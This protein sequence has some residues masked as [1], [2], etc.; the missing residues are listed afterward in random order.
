MQGKDKSLRAFINMFNKETIQVSTTNDMKKYLLE[1]DLCPCNDFIKD[2]GI[3]TPSSLDAIHLKA[4][5]YIQYEE[6]EA[7]NTTLDDQH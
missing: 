7:A 2:I 3:E 4:H 1:H 6:K 5:A